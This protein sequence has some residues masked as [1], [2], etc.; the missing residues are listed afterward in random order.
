MKNGACAAIGLMFLTSAA[1]ADDILAGGPLFGSPSQ[2]TAVCFVYNGGTTNV[3]L[4]VPRILQPGG[5]PLPLTSNTC[6]TTLAPG[7]ICQVTAVIDNLQYS[8]LTRIGPS[9]ANVHGMLEVRDQN[10][11][12]V[13]LQNTELR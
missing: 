13:I 3:T 6:R 8:C 4:A 10:P 1:Y 2:K 7:Q 12:Q 9:K 5:F 11:F